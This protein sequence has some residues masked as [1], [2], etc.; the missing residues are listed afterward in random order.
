M[1]RRFGRLS[2]CSGR[3]CCHLVG[4]RYQS[5]DA[6]SRGNIVLIRGNLVDISIDCLSGFTKSLFDPLKV[7]RS[8]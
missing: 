8:T 5:R 3:L 2:G 1:S 6:L 7:A 4:S